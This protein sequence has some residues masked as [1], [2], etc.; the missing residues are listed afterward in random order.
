MGLSTHVI[1]IVDNDPTTGGSTETR[2]TRWGRTT[3]SAGMASGVEVQPMPLVPGR[4]RK[5]SVS[6]QM[7]ERQTKRAFPVKTPPVSDRVKSAER[8]LETNLLRD[9]PVASPAANPS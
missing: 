1:P 7:R 4:R 3:A 5:S 8:T 9:M 6:F 2:L